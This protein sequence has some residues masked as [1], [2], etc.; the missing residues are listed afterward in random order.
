MEK[1]KQ[2]NLVDQ[3][4]FFPV[5][6]AMNFLFLS[7]VEKKER[8]K[9]FKKKEVARNIIKKKGELMIL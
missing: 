4:F 8:E 2:Q 6:L 7:V 3:K 9:P 5:L 1:S